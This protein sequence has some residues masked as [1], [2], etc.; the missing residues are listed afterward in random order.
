M[1][2]WLP[3]I[4][5]DSWLLP[6][7]DI[8]SW[9]QASGTQWIKFADIEISHQGSSVDVCTRHRGRSVD[10]YKCRASRL[11]V[12]AAA[13]NRYRSGVISARNRYR[14]VAAASAG[15]RYRSVVVAARHRYRFV[16]VAPAG[17]RY[18]SVVAAARYR[19]RFVAMGATYPIR[20]LHMF[21]LRPP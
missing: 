4:D 15:N 17:N 13:G 10:G 1:D 20:S 6:G 14:F 2:A 18:R 11:V 8:D 9:L 5:V 16:A 7:I 19:C 21:T 3:G 12:I